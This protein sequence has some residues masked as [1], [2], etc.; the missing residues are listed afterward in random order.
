[1]NHT[2]MYMIVIDTP[3]IVFLTSFQQAAN[4]GISTQL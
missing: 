2:K 1:M 4:A 3:V